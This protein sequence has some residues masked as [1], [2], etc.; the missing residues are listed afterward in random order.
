MPE[1]DEQ[2]A[3]MQRMVDLAVERTDLAVQR[4]KMSAERSEM[5]ADRSRMSAERSYLAAERTLSV[6][7]RTALALMVFGIAIDRFGLLLLQAPDS[8]GGVATSSV[9]VWT[10]AALV[11]FAVL[12]VVL[13]GARFRSYAAVYRRTHEIPSHHGPFL[14]P[15]FAG[16]VGL[17]GLGLLVLLLVSA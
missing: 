13:T 16:M 4:T 5:S 2:M 8:H 10:G 12:M 15:A 1:Q 17:F 11:A 3:A 14:A 6:W 9:S 7:V